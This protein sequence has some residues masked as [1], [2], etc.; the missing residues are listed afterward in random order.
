M[1]HAQ[2]GRAASLVLA[3]SH[4]LRNPRRRGVLG[5]I[6]RLERT[7]LGHRPE[8]GSICGDYFCRCH[9]VCCGDLSLGPK[10]QARLDPHHNSL[11]FCLERL[12]ASRLVAYDSIPF[13]RTCFRAVA[14]GP[15]GNCGAEEILPHRFP[16][17]VPQ[18]CCRRNLVPGRSFSGVAPF[19]IPVVEWAARPRAERC[20]YGSPEPGT[21]WIVHCFGRTLAANRPFATDSLDRVSCPTLAAV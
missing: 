16:S 10:Q 12:G 19:L 5:R 17:L 15:V 11:V 18:E 3:A 14:L 1:S 7:H 21:R 13:P 4:Q 6:R 8:C 9:C 2:Q 20:R